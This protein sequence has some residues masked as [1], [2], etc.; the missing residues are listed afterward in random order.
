VSQS[1][2]V[3]APPV[4]VVYTEIAAGVSH[5]L[6]RRSDGQLVAWGSNSASQ[7]GVLQGATP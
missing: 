4:G 3:P 7:L 1:T 6:A 2:N 5:S